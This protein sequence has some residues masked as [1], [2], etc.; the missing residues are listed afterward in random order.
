M[1]YSEEKENLERS[2]E[3]SKE[4]H[5]SALQ[6]LDDSRVEVQHLQKD[7]D[8][9]KKELEKVKEKQEEMQNV[10]KSTKSLLD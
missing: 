4:K 8:A 2:I 9:L 7:Y 5:S 6:D 3:E 10:R 1:A